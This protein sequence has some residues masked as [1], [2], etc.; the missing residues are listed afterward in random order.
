MVHFLASAACMRRGKGVETFSE[1]FYSF[2]R[3]NKDAKMGL[4]WLRCLFF[5]DRVQ[6]GH[7]VVGQGLFC[8]GHPHVLGV[9]IMRYI[10]ISILPVKAN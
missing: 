4:V 8:Y 6:L 9:R 5:A 10:G 1:G 7:S 2:C 3:L